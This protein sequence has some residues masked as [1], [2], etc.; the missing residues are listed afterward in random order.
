[1]G[2]QPSTASNMHEKKSIIDGESD[3]E[4]PE[5]MN[6]QSSL[7]TKSDIMS[8]IGKN[9]SLKIEKYQNEQ[10]NELLSEE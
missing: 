1:M 2:V 7:L 10:A 6:E 8:K 3:I 9:M 4:A 5:D